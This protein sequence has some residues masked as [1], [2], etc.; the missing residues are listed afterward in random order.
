MGVQPTIKAKGTLGELLA[1]LATLPD[2]DIATLDAEIS[3]DGAKWAP[4]PGPQEDAYFSEADELFYGG[5]AGGGK[6]HLMIGLSVTAHQRSLLLRRT[7]KEAEGWVD[8]YEEIYGDREGYNGQQ[9]TWRRDGRI[10]ELSG[11][12]LETDKQK[13]KGRPHD[14]IGFDE[15]SDFS[16]TQYTFIIGWNRS[17]VPGQ[18]CRIVAAGNPPTTPEGLWVLKRWAA[19]LDPNHPNPAI[20]GELRWYTTG[21]EGKEIEVDGPGPHMVNGEEIMARSRTFIPAKLSDNPDLSAS[22]YAATLAALP[23]E[24]RDAYRD[25]KFDAALKDG[26][27]QTIPTAWVRAAQARWTDRPPQ[28]V[29]MCAMGVDVAQGGSDQT[30]IARRHDG[31]FAPLIAVPGKS[32]P[33]GGSVAGLVVSHRRDSATVVVDMGGGYGGAA[34]E[35][36]KANQIEVKGYKGAEA[37]PGRTA[38]GQLKFANRRSRAYWRFREALYPGQLGGSPIALPANDPELVA[39]LTA[40]TFK[41]GPQGIQI[42]P[43]DQLIKRLGRSPDRGDAVVMAWEEGLKQANVPGGWAGLHKQQQVKAVM[44]H[45]SARRRR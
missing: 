27:F 26:A 15:V 17:T 6:S 34:F 45:M 3:A 35:W 16:E 18:R 33:D 42:E 41:V 12:Q 14:L 28:G 39:D 24:L 40:P 30:I 31:W 29:P 25:G 1:C 4:T 5:Q 2:D 23:Q 32:T 38:E 21:E 9:N 10:I 22:G 20:P 7:A 11:C 8:D 44:G 36:L 19:W 37:G 13:H 43:K